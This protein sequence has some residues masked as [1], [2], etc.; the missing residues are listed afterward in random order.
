MRH[1]DGKVNQLFRFTQWKLFEF[2]QDGE[3]YREICEP[4]FKGTM[5]SKRL[6]DGAKGLIDIDIPATFQK[7][8][9]VSLPIWVDNAERI[10]DKTAELIKD[11]DCQLILLKAD[12]CQLTVDYED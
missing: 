3:S 8:Y 2:N 6:N 1:V 9:E 11:L 10:T 5:Y 7:A 12:D 4:T